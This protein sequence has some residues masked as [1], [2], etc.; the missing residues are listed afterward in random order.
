MMLKNCIGCKK[1]TVGNELHVNCYGLT[2]AGSWF[3]SLCNAYSNCI[4]SQYSCDLCVRTIHFLNQSASK[5]I[6]ANRCNTI[7]EPG[8]SS[9]LQKSWIEQAMTAPTALRSQSISSTR[10]H[11]THIQSIP[12]HW[13]V[14]ERDLWVLITLLGKRRAHDG[15]IANVCET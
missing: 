7:M 12:L 3:S 6:S 9:I 5:S 13:W 15:Q 2:Q 1:I 11:R 10:N 8:G 14:S 4:L